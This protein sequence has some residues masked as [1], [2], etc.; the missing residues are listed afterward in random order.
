[1][2]VLTEEEE[3]AH[4]RESFRKLSPACLFNLGQKRYFIAVRKLD[5]QSWEVIELDERCR[6]SI[7]NGQ[8]CETLTLSFE[9]MACLNICRI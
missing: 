9:Q 1:M 3:L 4:R 8:S 7:I 2:K 5:E 6:E